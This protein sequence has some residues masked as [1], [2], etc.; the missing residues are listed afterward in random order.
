[1]QSDGVQDRWAVDN[2]QVIRTLME[3]AALYRRT[4]TPVCF[5]TG[6]L[7]VAA[8]G[9]GWVLDLDSARGFALYWMAV[10]TTTL[11]ICLTIM[12]RQALL[13]NEPFWSAPT[14]R[15]AQAM[16][17]ALFAGCI[18]G[19]VMGAPS[20]REPLHAWWLPGIWM[21]LFGCATHAAGFFMP[22]GMKWFGWAFAALGSTLLLAINARAHASGMPSLRYAHVVMGLTFG[23][24]HLT[25]AAYLAATDK[26]VSSR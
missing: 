9:L 25:Y 22:R 11:G 13:E 18:A 16:L 12:R 17:P 14:R 7:G 1:M 8:A 4:L 20:W 24:L 6:V 26:K 15:V 21:M 19:V 3:R 2:L 23:G 10:A 5:A